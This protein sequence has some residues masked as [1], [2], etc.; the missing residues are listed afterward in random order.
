MRR[1]LFLS[2]IYGQSMFPTLKHK[3]RILIKKIIP[4]QI[5]I[6][7][8]VVYRRG[9]L[10]VSH[11]V[12]KIKNSEEGLIFYVKGDASSLIDRVTDKEIVGKVVG[13][14]RGK[15]IRILLF[16]NTRFYCFFVELLNYFKEFIKRM[17]VSI[18]SL[19]IMRKVVKKIFPLRKV[20][21]IFVKDL[22]REDFR[23]FF[24]FFPPFFNRHLHVYGILAKY[25][26]RSIGK[27]WILS[28]KDKFFLYGPY[29]KILY[30]VRG[31]G[32][33]L[34]KK[35]LEFVVKSGKKDGVYII[36][37]KKINDKS[38]VKFYETFIKDGFC[39]FYPSNQ[40]YY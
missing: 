12:V 35:A 30:R 40:E 11:R 7:D 3:D 22:Q 8:I 20:K 23:S 36:Y 10:N 2:Y 19:K 32:S 6:R 25:K 26:N 16:E 27:I 14:I 18:Y 17:L 5:K 4:S 34:V 13:V 39:R 37:P 28:G 31:V 33:K 38:F 9:N 21:Y 24:N 1:G 15:K 29:V